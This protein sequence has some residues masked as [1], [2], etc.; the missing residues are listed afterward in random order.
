MILLNIIAK[1]IYLVVPIIARPDDPKTCALAALPV[2][3][4]SQMRLRTLYNDE[5]AF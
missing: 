4:N 3:Q 1:N 5:A 2:A